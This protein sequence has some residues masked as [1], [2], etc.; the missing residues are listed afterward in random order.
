MAEFDIND[1]KTSLLTD[2]AMV[3]SD[4]KIIEEGGVTVKEHYITDE[5][6]KNSELR[7]QFIVQELQRSMDKG[8]S[9]IDLQFERFNSKTSNI[10]TKL[11]SMN[12]KLTWLFGILSSVVIIPILIWT[13]TQV[14]AYLFS[15]IN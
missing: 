10:D 2:T 14:I 12:S 1:G 4:G 7:Q 5:E 15:N 9:N 6:L 11:D 3:D 8:F 13:A